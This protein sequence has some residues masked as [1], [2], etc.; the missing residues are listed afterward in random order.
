MFIIHL[1]PKWLTVPLFLELQ[2]LCSKASYE[3]CMMVLILLQLD[4]QHMYKLYRLSHLFYYYYMI[5]SAH[6]GYKA[7]VTVTMIS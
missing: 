5:N 6:Q 2:H 3:V 7:D 4:W 1:F